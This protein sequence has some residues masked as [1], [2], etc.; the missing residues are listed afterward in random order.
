MLDRLPAAPAGAAIALG[1]ALLLGPARPLHAQPPGPT[2]PGAEPPAAAVPAAATG[3]PES[4]P[5]GRPPARAARPEGD[6][7]GG[8][9]ARL[10]P[11]RHEVTRVGGALVA[12]LGLLL[13]LRAVVRRAA[14]GLGGGGRPSGVVEVL[15][16]YP[17][18]RGQ[19]LLVLRWARR[20]LLVQSSG[21]T[22]TTLSEMRDPD[23]VASLLARVEAG[24]RRGP[25]F[26]AV[27]HRHE[28]DH[29]RQAEAAAAAPAARTAPEVGEVIDLT[30]RRGRGAMA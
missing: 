7:A 5:L 9:L 1:L 17:I 2:R 23:E 28:V 20:V 21:G 14:P 13:V 12:V 3:A 16:R 27:L 4:L 15:A 30:R 25:G 6:G 29:A 8:L 19:Q 11:R 24:S 26:D 10:D 22:M 18:A